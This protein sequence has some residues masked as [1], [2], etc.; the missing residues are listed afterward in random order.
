MY[1]DEINLFESYVKSTKIENS[2]FKNKNN[3][4]EVINNI[5]SA[6]D[7]AIYCPNELKK[8]L[9]IYLSELKNLILK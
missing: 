1:S 9:E 7:N 2:T 8:K 4:F 3:I 5:E 6:I